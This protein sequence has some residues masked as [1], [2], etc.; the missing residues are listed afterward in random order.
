MLIATDTVLALDTSAVFPLI[1]FSFLF[2]SFFSFLPAPFAVLGQ[3]I[4]L[5]NKKTSSFSHKDIHNI[6]GKFKTR[7]EM[8]KF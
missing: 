1:F 6:T 8:C 3:V 5:S 7:C 4:N 2:S